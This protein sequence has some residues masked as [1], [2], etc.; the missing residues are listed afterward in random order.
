MPFNF[1]SDKLFNNLFET[2][3]KFYAKNEFWVK[4]VL[5]EKIKKFF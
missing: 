1:S 3:I 5:L 4:F 2:S